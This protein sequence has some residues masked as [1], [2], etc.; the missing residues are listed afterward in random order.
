V[1]SRLDQREAGAASH[2][3]IEAS[4]TI[5]VH[6]VRDANMRVAPGCYTPR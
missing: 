2:C 4:L 1:R 6:G 5:A 3:I